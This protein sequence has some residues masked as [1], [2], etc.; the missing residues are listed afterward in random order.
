MT[1]A[2]GGR[3]AKIAVEDIVRVGR[4]LGMRQLSV[5]AVASGLGV[6]STA[7]YR[8]VEGRWGLERLIG[9]SILA[10]LRLHDDPEHDAPRHLLSFA[11]QMRS[12]A[13]RHPGLV[14]YLQLLFPRGESG[15]RLLAV[16]VEA[17]GRRGYAPD[18]AIALSSS[19]A[20]LTIAMTASEENSAAAE[21]ADAGGLAREREAVV[22]RLAND[23][24]LGSAPS[25]LPQIERPEYVRLLL[26]ASIKGL[27][28]VCPPGRPVT[29]MIAEL[30]AAGAGV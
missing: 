15:Q 27:V 18:A 21:V 30:A 16:E 5:K 4:E 8:H 28:E 17:L 20:S 22:D 14:G 29:E 25:T 24:R 3:P 1:R 9:E 26:T 13:L 10:E 19:V 6:S 23:D 11:M 7:L 2:V 12:F